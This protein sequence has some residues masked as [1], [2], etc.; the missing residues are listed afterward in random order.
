MS[1]VELSPWTEPKS[2]LAHQAQI[3]HARSYA[4]WLL[5]AGAEPRFG[6]LLSSGELAEQRWCLLL[7]E[8]GVLVERCQITPQ[9][10]LPQVLTQHRG[11]HFNRK[12]FILEGLEQLQNDELIDVIQTLNGQR[13]PLKQSATWVT[14]LFRSAMSLS[15][16]LRHAPHAW[17][18][19]ERRCLMWESSERLPPRSDQQALA[20][21]SWAHPLEVLYWTLDHPHIPMTTQSFDRSVR[22]G[23]QRPTVGAHE[24][25]SGLEAIWRGDVDFKARRRSSGVGI[26]ESLSEISIEE[27]FAALLYRC[28]SLSAGVRV[29]LEEKVT[30]E[31]RWLLGIA[32]SSKIVPMQSELIS[33]IQFRSNL[34]QNLSPSFED[35]N[36]LK[37][38]RQV[39]AEKLREQGS[40]FA[41][42]GLWLAEG[43]AAQGALEQCLEALC[44]VEQDQR[45]T[46]EERFYAGERLVELYTLTQARAEAQILIKVLFER[47][48][49]LG[50]PLYEVRAFC[51]KANH[52]GALDPSRGER[53][54]Q[55]AKR[56]ALLHGVA[57]NA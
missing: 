35:L 25:W 26:I 27:A 42:T 44:S 5:S 50:S 31:Q 28:Q 29:Q 38:L 11:D 10:P 57:L 21:P 45:C 43:F 39:Q 56:L 48:Y 32:S 16:F 15:T 9:R 30:A 40:L 34:D 14:L 18:L 7:E 8:Q 20:L 17:S 3:W 55:R 12:L 52:L 24:R 41:L 53:E 33:W 36:E 22:A 4:R 6:A 13:S 37:L 47:A 49:A 19:L 2:D 54:R 51:T 1:L 23:V 46:L